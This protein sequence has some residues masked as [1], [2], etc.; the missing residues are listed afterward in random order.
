MFWD[1]SAPTPGFGQLPGFTIPGDEIREQLDAGRLRFLRME[2]ESHDV[3][4]RDRGGER[5]AIVRGAERVLRVP[6]SSHSILA[7]HIRTLTSVE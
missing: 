6:S 3:V 5:L 2:L 7:Q 4:A 1:H